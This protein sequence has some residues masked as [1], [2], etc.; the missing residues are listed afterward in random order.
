[1]MVEAN[2]ISVPAGGRENLSNC[3]R[4]HFCF[5]LERL[6]LFQK[7]LSNKIIF[8]ILQWQLSTSKR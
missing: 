5:E 2:L 6:I 7:I 1:M 8:R 4:F 3:N